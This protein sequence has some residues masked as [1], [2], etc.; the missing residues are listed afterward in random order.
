MVRKVD[1]VV[2]RV[3]RL[4]EGFVGDFLFPCA[5]GVSSFDSPPSSHQQKNLHSAGGKFANATGQ[6]VG[7]LKTFSRA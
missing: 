4:D 5:V 2:E 7:G 6:F 1:V 3:E